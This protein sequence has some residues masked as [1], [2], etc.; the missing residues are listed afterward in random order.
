MTKSVDL[1]APFTT[2]YINKCKTLWYSAG[3]PSDLK[4]ILRLLEKE[5]CRDEH[6]R[7]PHR[8]TLKGWIAEYGWFEWADIMDAEANALVEVDIIN[9]KAQMLREQAKRGQELQELGMAFLKSSDGGFDSSSAA[10]QAV[11]RGAELERSSRGIG[12]TLAKLAK[13]SDGDLM[14]E[15]RK[16]LEQAARSGQVIDAEEVPQ[17]KEPDEEE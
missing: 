3:R 17:E 15:I 12:E 7:L 9:Q 11:I 6:G 13:M 16:G 10:V 8:L 2:E 4:S 5:N 14:E 1:Y